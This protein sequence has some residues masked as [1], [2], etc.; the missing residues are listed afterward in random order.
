MAN[1]VEMVQM[2]SE[3]LAEYKRFVAEKE[4]K[5]KELQFAHQREEYKTL[6][7]E[8][9][10]KSLAK[11]QTVSQVLVDAKANVLSDFDTLIAMKAELFG[12]KKEE[13]KSH[14][15]TNANNTIRVLVGNYTVDNYR[16]TVNEGIAMVKEVVK[17]LARDEE[18]SALV[19]AILK[20][21]SKDKQGNL[22]ASK[23]IELSELADKINN[24]KLRL[25]VKIIKESYMPLVSKRF[26][27]I[28]KKDPTTNEFKDIPLTMTEA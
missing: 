11:L 25:G 23:V 27:R 10:D 9:V 3:Q 14:T 18:S 1:N 21:L 17:S 8:V 15:F 2:T 13:Q 26:I 22:K 28:M 6:V 20:L 19:D 7:E 16:D 5:E 24:D 12:I 4:K